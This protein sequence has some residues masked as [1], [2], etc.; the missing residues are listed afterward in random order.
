MSYQ[1]ELPL[2]LEVS[3]EVF[4]WTEKDV[5]QLRMYVLTKTLSSLTDGRACL[6]VR[7][8]SLDWLMDEAIHPFSFRVCCESMDVNPEVLRELVVETIK[9][10][11]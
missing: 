8:E 1:Y 4:I 9:R 7:T 11:S 10:N 3:E 2:V 6:K 5:E